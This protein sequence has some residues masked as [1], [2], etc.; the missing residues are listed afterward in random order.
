MELDELY[1]RI[2]ARLVAAMDAGDN[3]ELRAGVRRAILVVRDEFGRESDG[4]PG[5]SED[6]FG[7]EVGWNAQDAVTE[8]LRRL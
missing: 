7:W 5:P 6:R 1:E 2:N 3:A 4:S 8:S